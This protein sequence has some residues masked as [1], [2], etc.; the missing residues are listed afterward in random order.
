MKA[1]L[2][3]IVFAAN[4]LAACGGTASLEPSGSEATGET[5]E[6]IVL[7]PPDAACEPVLPCPIDEVWDEAACICRPHVDGGPA[8]GPSTCGAG[9]T[10]CDFPGPAGLCEPRCIVGHVCPDIACRPPRPDAGCVDN[11]LCI[12]GTSWEPALCRCVPDPLPIPA[13]TN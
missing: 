7:P 3:V 10:C 12:E 2:R 6:A 1:N 5:T 11:V 9:E 4:A 13:T 8:C